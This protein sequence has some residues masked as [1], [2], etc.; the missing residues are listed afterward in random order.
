M[1]LENKS[2]KMRCKNKGFGLIELLVVMGVIAIISAVA[3][4]AILDWRANTQLRGA[5]QELRGAL[6]LA[7]S[8]AIQEGKTVIVDLKTDD[9]W[10]YDDYSVYVDAGDG[11][12][13]PPNFEHDP[14]EPI[15][16]DPKL[17]EGIHIELIDPA[18]GKPAD[19]YWP[20]NSQLK[21]R[22]LLTAVNHHNKQIAA[23]IAGGLF[24]VDPFQERKISFEL[25][26]QPGLLKCFNP[27]YDGKKVNLLQCH[28]Q[29]WPDPIMFD[30]TGRCWNPLTVVVVNVKGQKFAIEITPFSIGKTAKVADDF[31]E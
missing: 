1:I 12:G 20:G 22:Q 28:G 23:G 21:A 9:H 4:P 26:P 6:Q 15:V 16:C 17:P 18:T 3:T 27:F 13:G 5:A 25:Y 19:I 10:I 24:G 11:S 31:G 2:C 29:T 7:R 8:R 30:A 14:Q